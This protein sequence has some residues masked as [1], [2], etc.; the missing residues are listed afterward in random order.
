[1]K[2]ELLEYL[3]TADTTNPPLLFLHGAFHG[4]WCWKDYFLP[5][6]SGQ[7]FPCYALSFRGHGGSEGHEKLDAASLEDYMHDVLEILPLLHDKPVIIGHSMGG[8]IT[9]MLLNE[10]P[11]AIRT[12]VLMSSV[13][14]DGLR[15]DMLRL[16]FRHFSTMVQMFT[17]NKS[18]YQRL[19]ASLLLAQDMPV[20]TKRACVALLQ[21][22]SFKVWQEMSKQIVPKSMQTNL[23]VL[24]LGSKS[25]KL[26]SLGSVV[27][28][29]KR[30]HT[31]P[32]IFDHVSH[33]MM[34]DPHWKDVAD[35]ILTYLNNLPS[36]DRGNT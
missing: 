25:D 29:G 3:P 26:I 34:L 1:M 15:K 5:Y 23:P 2:L 27:A 13:S 11:D 32:I 7:G 30:F 4:A 9:Q 8:A 14:P 36:T 21:P 10:H 19:I 12:A 16:F 33:D 28:M 20:A 17:S 31:E 24:V 35:Q 18:K 6:F 22:E